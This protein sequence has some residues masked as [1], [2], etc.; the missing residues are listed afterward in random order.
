MDQGITNVMTTDIV[1]CASDASLV[2]AAAI[3]RDHGARALVLMDHGEVRGIVS[4]RDIV[5][6]CV[7]NGADLGRAMA[8]DASARPVPTVDHA[9]SSADAA[10]VM[11]AHGAASV[12]VVDEGRLLGVVTADE[13]RLASS[14]AAS[15][16]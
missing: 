2:E 8:S 16:G 15:H 14:D 5:I 6:R 1:A 4:A 12:A 11:E 10:R 3:M 9:A 7:A 13:I